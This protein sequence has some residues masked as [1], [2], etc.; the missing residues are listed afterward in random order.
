L[1][2]IGRQTWGARAAQSTGNN[3][4]AHP[5]G[6][7]IHYAA[8]NV[9]N[10]AHDLCAGTVANIQ[11]FHQD[12]RGYADVAY[13]LLVCQHGSVFE[14]RGLSKGSAA[15][16]TTQA[17]LD[18]YAVCALTGPDD[19]PT[20]ALLTGLREAVQLCRDAGAGPK[21]L[22]HRD[23]F[24]TSCPGD[25][26]YAWVQAGMPV[27]AAKTKPPAPPPAPSEDD[28]LSKEAQAW[29]EGRMDAHDQFI[30]SNLKATQGREELARL[31]KIEA[32]LQ[33]VLAAL[34]KAS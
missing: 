15:N 4:S 21:V 18:F 10:Q 3:I 1:S 22:G 5:I 33:Q 8:A 14:G 20:P 23:L 31:T 32:T 24:A 2:I 9:G 12:T 7:A 13:N 11:R 34:G 25:A 30:L 29:I 16:G 17:N 26:L 28:M 19:T 27:A 6:V